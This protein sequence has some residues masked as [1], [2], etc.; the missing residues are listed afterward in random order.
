[1]WGA[2]EDSNFALLVKFQV[3]EL[4]TYN[5]G[6]FLYADTTH[7]WVGLIRVKA[8]SYGKEVRVFIEAKLA[9]V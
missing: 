6:Y 7:S 2:A 9:R 5:H 3:A 1:M 8:L 4:L